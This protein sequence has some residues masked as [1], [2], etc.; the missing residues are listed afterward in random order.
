MNQP[1]K[2][3]NM[4]GS[5]LDEVVV[6][7]DDENNI[8]FINVQ[9]S[10][11]IKSMLV[12]GRSNEEFK[13]GNEVYEC[14]KQVDVVDDKKIYLEV[15][16]NI[17]NEVVDSLTHL[18]NRRALEKGLDD[19]ENYSSN[20]VVMIDIDKF[21]EINDNIGHE[22]GDY[23][24]QKIANIFIHNLRDYDLAIRYGGDEF[25]LVLKNCTLYN[26]C[27]KLSDL[28]QKVN[29]LQF[30]KLTDRDFLTLSFGMEICRTKEDF[31]AA[32]AAAD[33]AMYRSKQGGGN[34]ISAYEKL[35]EDDNL[36]KYGNNEEVIDSF[37]AFKKSMAA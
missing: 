1:N 34:K 12:L 32:K 28:R 27:S 37:S 30:E 17:T 36:T 11:K 31:E 25:L 20:V 15:Y 24:L 35:D 21:K 2:W 18:K 33:E 6:V 8:K 10:T 26:A 19:L 16:K 22:Y 7:R 3:M 5:M 23:V 4:I 9:D 13:I 14:K 29:R